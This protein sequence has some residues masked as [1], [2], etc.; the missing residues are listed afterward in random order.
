MQDTVWVMKMRFKPVAISAVNAGTTLLIKLGVPTI[1]AK[2]FERLVGRFK[3]GNEYELRQVRKKRSL[4]ANSYFWILADEI[5]SVLNTTKEEVYME[6]VKRVGVF[7]TMRFRDSKAMNRFKLQ[8][9]ETGLGWLTRT[10]DADKCI[11]Q[12][13]YGSS[14]YDTKE[15]ARLIDEAVSEAKSLGIET[16]TPLELERMKDE[17]K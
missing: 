9:Q 5:A 4:D 13:Y 17:W 8:W 15:M 1:Y 3:A 12:A 6:L 2:D 7:E 14:R 10:V 16:L 11:L